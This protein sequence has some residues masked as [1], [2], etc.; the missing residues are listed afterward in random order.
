M[1]YRVYLTVP[2]DQ[3]E[4][5]DGFVTVDTGL[6]YGELI[7]AVI[8]CFMGITTQKAQITI[9]EVEDGE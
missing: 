8:D 4:L 3:V 9:S 6:A 5:A 7:Q 2:E 1:S